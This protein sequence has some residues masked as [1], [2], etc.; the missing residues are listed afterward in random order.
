MQTGASAPLWFGFVA[1]AVSVA[2]CVLWWLDSLH[3]SRWTASFELW[4]MSFRSTN[5]GSKRLIPTAS[6]LLRIFQGRPRKAAARQYSIALGDVLKLCQLSFE[7]SIFVQLRCSFRQVRRSAIGNQVSPSLASLTVAVLEEQ[8]ARKAQK[9]LQNN[10]SRIFIARYIDNRLIIYDTTIAQDADFQEFCQLDF[11]IPPV[12]LENEP[13]ETFRVCLQD[14]R[15]R[16]VHPSEEYRFRPFTPAGTPAHRLAPVQS[17]M[18]NAASYSWPFKQAEDDTETLVQIYANRE[19]GF[20]PIHF[21]QHTREV[22]APTTA[23]LWKELFCSFLDVIGCSF[24]RFFTHV[25]DFTPRKQKNT[26]ILFAMSS[27]LTRGKVCVCVQSVF[28]D[29]KNSRIVIRLD[30]SSCPYLLESVPTAS[31]SGTL[32]RMGLAGPKLHSLSFSLL[33][34]FL[35]LKH[36]TG[37]CTHVDVT[38][39]DQECRKTRQSEK[40]SPTNSPVSFG[41]KQNSAVLP[42]HFG[43][44]SVWCWVCECE[45]VMSVMWCWVCDVS[46]VMLSVWC[47]ACDVSCVMLSVWCWVCDVSCV[48]LSV[49]YRGVWC[50]LCD[51]WCVIF[52]VWCWV[53][54]VS[55]VILSVWY[56]G[57]W[58]QLCDVECVMLSV[59]CQLCDIE[60]GSVGGA[61][62]G[63][64]GGAAGCNDKNKN[65]TIECGELKNYTFTSPT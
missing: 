15:I 21:T 64:G 1:G 13:H 6:P 14:H 19:S 45:R 39:E 32:T 9:F 61:A 20:C 10:G 17:R 35:F 41:S 36:S 37:W 26:R 50:Q 16:F 40:D 48:I 58:C 46:C 22:F 29:L 53:C 31:P 7:A 8:W 52:S 3:P 47:W 63:E 38:S 12:Q 43:T 2:S 56:R 11:Y 49:W 34:N 28:Q 60:C 25:Y 54:D 5:V 57:V 30:R 51:V 62:G 33:L 55:C 44:S 23:S 27:P 4:P 24:L 18:S 59:R 42:E 65:P